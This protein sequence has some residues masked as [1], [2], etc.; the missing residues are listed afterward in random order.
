VK[1]YL[2]PVVAG[3]AVFGSVT[4][5]AATL[6][7][8]SSSLGSGNATV[9]ACNTDAGVSYTGGFATTPHVYQVATTTV[10]TPGPVTP[11]A[12]VCAGKTYKI[13]FLDSSNVQV[14]TEVTGTIGSD[15]TDTK[16]V[17]GQGIAASGVANVAV[18]ITG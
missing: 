6:N 9:A 7:V 17:A 10:T 5:F 1:K 3:M 4:A 15:G 12:A 14:G 16:N 13:T 18:V 2:I 8:T 11:L